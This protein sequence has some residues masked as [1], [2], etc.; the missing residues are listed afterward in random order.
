M[1]TS[2]VRKSNIVKLLS[3]FLIC[4]LILGLMITGVFAA[5]SGTK[6]TAQLSP[7]IE[8]VLDGEQDVYK[9]QE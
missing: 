2:K 6:V 7:Q 5:S 4:T 8:I 3:V 9:R 1:I